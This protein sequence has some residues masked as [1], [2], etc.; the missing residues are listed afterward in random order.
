M[1]DTKIITDNMANTLT[2]TDLGIGEKYTGKVRDMYFVD[3]TKHG[4]ISILISTDRQSAFDRLLGSIPFKGQVLASASAWWFKNTTHIVKNHMISQPDPNVIIAKKCKVLPIEFV[5]RGYIT[6]STSTSLWKQYNSGVRNYCG[7]DFPEGLVKNQKLESNVLTP[8]TKEA[9]H[10]RPISPTDIV[11]EGWL[12][13]EQWDYASQKTLELFEFGQAEAEKRGLILVDTKYEFGIDL[14]TNEIILIDEIHT[15]DSSRFWIKE[16]YEQ[17][18]A[19]GEEPENIDKEFFRLW[20]ADNCDPY[21][22]TEIPNAP[23][24]LVVELASRYIKQYEMITGEDF[25]IDN[26]N[27]IKQRIKDNILNYLNS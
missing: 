24:E 21:N 7:V 9:D 4:D 14:E 25:V 12:T 8:T 22:D 26:T 18:I 20:F 13:Q 23:D 15:P 17:K 3:A 5:V 10:D 16:T 27:N 19:N 2:E 11:K 1:I 6:G